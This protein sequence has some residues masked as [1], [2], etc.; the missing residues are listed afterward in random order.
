M[1][2]GRKHDTSRVDMVG[3]YILRKMPHEMVY[4]QYWLDQ[5]EQGFFEKDDPPIRLNERYNTTCFVEG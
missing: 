2:S 4:P 3:E 5:L 1:K